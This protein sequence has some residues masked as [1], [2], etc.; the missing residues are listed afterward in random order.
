MI[1]I[2]LVILKHILNIAGELEAVQSQGF[3]FIYQCC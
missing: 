3:V 2:V 1:T